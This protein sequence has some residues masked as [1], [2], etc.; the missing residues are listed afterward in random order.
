VR[1]KPGQ[2][3]SGEQDFVAEMA[4]AIYMLEPEAVAVTLVS[5]LVRRLDA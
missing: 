4:Y 1:R 2:A 5:E 3:V